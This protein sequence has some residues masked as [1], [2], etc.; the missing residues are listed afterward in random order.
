MGWGWGPAGEE[1][2]SQR[3]T[4]LDAERHWEALAGVLGFFFFYQC[5]RVIQ[6]G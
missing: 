2:G 4:G 3:S 5:S 6:E 1:V